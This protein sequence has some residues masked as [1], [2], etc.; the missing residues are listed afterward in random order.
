MNIWITWLTFSYIPVHGILWAR[1]LT[2]VGGRSVEDS[3]VNAARALVGYMAGEL[4]DKATKDTYTDTL[5]ARSYDMAGLL[6]NFLGE[7][8]F[9]FLTGHVPVGYNITI[10]YAK[11]TL[12]CQCTFIPFEAEVHSR[13]TEVKAITYSNLQVEMSPPYD[14]YVV[15]DI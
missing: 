5:E 3:F 14:I 15:V 12:T 13:G 7:V 8:L 6:H 9:M 10:D 11:H 2:R 4:Y 1:A